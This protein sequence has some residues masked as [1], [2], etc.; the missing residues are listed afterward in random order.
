[1]TES[2]TSVQPNL[3]EV[4]SLGQWKDMPHDI[5]IVLKSS[6]ETLLTP[7]GAGV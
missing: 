5:I 3:D 4:E 6:S 2:K 7:Q 1:M